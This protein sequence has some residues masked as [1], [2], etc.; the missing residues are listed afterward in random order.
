[1]NVDINMYSYTYTIVYMGTEVFTN[2]SN[3]TYNTYYIEI[4]ILMQSQVN[5]L[6]LH[7]KV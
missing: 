1:M 4:Y 7:I 3:D 5:Y 2:L 6:N